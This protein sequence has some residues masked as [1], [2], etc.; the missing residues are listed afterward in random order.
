MPLIAINVSMFQ[1]LIGRLKTIG[2]SI[3][4]FNP[5]NVSIPYRQAKNP[6]RSP[7]V[8]INVSMFQSLIGRLKTRG[9]D[10]RISDCYVQFQSLIGRLKTDKSGRKLGEW[11][12]VSIPY[13]QAKN[14]IMERGKLFI[15]QVSIPYRQAKNLDTISLFHNYSPWFQSLIGRL[16]TVNI[17]GNFQPDSLVSIPYR[18]AKNWNV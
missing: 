9:K 13:R 11:F 12:I 16:K 6:K 7:L 2:V 5:Y 10:P 1:S 17:R 4:G 8:A 14:I 3:E 18:Q 15:Q